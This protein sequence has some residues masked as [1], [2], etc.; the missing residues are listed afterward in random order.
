MNMK[1]ATFTF[2][3]SGENH[4]GMEQRGCIVKK[5]EGF[6]REDLENVKSILEKMGIECE[7]VDL[8]NEL[9][10]DDMKVDV[11]EAY[12]LVIRN[13]LDSILKEGGKSIEDMYTEI[14]KDEL[15]DKKYWCR[16]RTRVLNK[17]ARWNNVICDIDREAD[18]ENKKGKLIS[19]DRVSC[20]NLVKQFIEKIGDSK[21]KG[22]VC[23][24]NY[25]YNL[26]KTGIGFHGDA[27]RRKVIALRI[28]D[29]MSLCYNWYH[30]SK[31][32]GKKKE[33]VLNNGDMYIMSEKAV[34]TDWK[35]RSHKTL[36]HSAGLSDCRY[37][38][39]KV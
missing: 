18:Y 20:L 19:W 9:L 8:K 30:Y 25:Y 35:K 12:V 28:G 5:G 24:G 23:E 27:E 16:R 15:W 21:M 3:E 26:K 32:I 17:L 36:R 29:T 39:V 6:N 14:F 10:N 31:G 33:I 34:G 22:F 13:V 11:E 38:K 1:T 2:C 7:M 4:V 37:V